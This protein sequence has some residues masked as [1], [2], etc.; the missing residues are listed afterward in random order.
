[1]LLELIGIA[2]DRARREA[3]RTDLLAALREREARL[4]QLV[5]Q[6][7]SAQED[8]RR[9]VSHELHDG[10]AQTATALARLIEA[11]PG[12]GAAPLDRDQRARLAGIARDLVTELRGVIAGLR[13]TMLDDLGLAAAVRAL[14]D[15]LEQA[16]YAV[17]V[18][19]AEAVVSDLPPAA[20]TA[21]FRVAQEATANIRK[22]SGGPCRVAISLSAAPG[23]RR[24]LVVRD[25]GHGVRGLAEDLAPDA[26][27][28]SG[29]TDGSHIGLAVMRE[30][31]AA[32]GGSLDWCSSPAGVTVTA[33]LRAG[34]TG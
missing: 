33:D 15:S 8:E 7:F 3:E 13:P 4:E 24:R 6:I 16:G 27:A 34:L 31:M 14:A 26:A 5:G 32:I 23:G 21:L 12:D 30:R 20:A 19:I 18:R 2:L 28:R 9:R 25:F 1:M 22:H 17:D 10:V 29:G 11:A